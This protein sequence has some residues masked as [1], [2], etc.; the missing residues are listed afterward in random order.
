M[1]KLVLDTIGLPPTFKSV[2][3][4][5]PQISDEEVLVKVTAVGLCYH[6]VLISEGILRRGV[7]DELV[8]G[9]EFSGEVIRIG[10]AIQDLNMNDKVIATLTSSCGN[11]TSCIQ[12]NDYHCPN[13]DGFGH[14]IDGGLSQYIALR[15]ENIIKLPESI[16]PI[17]ASLIACPIG[18]SFKALMDVAN[19]QQEHTVVIFGAGGG[20]GIHALQIAKSVGAD[21]IAFTSSLNKLEK[22]NVFTD[23]AFLIEED[24]DPAEI[25]FS[26]TNNKGADLV[27]NPVGG[28]L[29]KSSIRCLSIGGK[30]LLLGQVDS[31]LVSINIAEI[32]FREISIIGSVG[33]DRSHIGKVMKMISEGVIHP[34]IGDTMPFQNISEAYKALSSNSVPGRIVLT[35]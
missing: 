28:A 16:D 5:I 19:I 32:L 20:L 30:M 6:D 4:D 17:V 9:H 8:L 14:G 13:S 12:G 29:F 25:V 35:L 22:L 21:V 24:L 11:C 31:S 27:F 34:V 23:Q 1:K 7:K 15:R 10:K 26:L 3:T 33:A 2:E 18:V